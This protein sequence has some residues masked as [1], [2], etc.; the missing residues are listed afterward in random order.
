MFA[1][2]NL[3]LTAKNKFCLTFPLFFIFQRNLLHLLVSDLSL[4]SLETGK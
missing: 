4:L 1:S 2:N 3:Y